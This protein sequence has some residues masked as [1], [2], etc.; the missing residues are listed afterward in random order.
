MN[1]MS[2]R[3]RVKYNRF[4]NFHEAVH[5]EVNTVITTHI[6]SPKSLGDLIEQYYMNEQ[7]LDYF[8]VIDVAHM[9][10]QHIEFIEIIKELDKAALISA[11]ADGIMTKLIM[12]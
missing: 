4:K 1:V 9:L 2:I 10:L 11:T 12:K 7:R 5:N 6:T 3:L 8:L